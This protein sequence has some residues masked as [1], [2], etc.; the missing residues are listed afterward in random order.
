[1]N[2]FFFFLHLPAHRI[3]SHTMSQHMLPAPTPTA[4]SPS[5]TSGHGVALMDT[6][7]PTQS[8]VAHHLQSQH[9]LTTN[10]QQQSHH[11]LQHGIHNNNGGGGGDVG[12]DTALLLDRK[13]MIG[14]GNRNGGG[15]DVGAGVVGVSGEYEQHRSPKVC[16]TPPTVNY[17][18]SVINVHSSSNSNNNTNNNNNGGGVDRNGGSPS[19]MHTNSNVAVYYEHIKYTGN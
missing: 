11:M 13:L 12:N 6:I 1:M 14:G 10:Q 8:P 15:D 9:T 19:I 16:V 2:L 4:R 17:N 3:D 5:S 18:G 7:T